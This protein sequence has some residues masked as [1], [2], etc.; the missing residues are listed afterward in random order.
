MDKRIK[1]SCPGKTYA[2][3]TREVLQ[4]RNEDWWGSATAVCDVCRTRVP[5]RNMVKLPIHYLD[6]TIHDVQVIRD[7]S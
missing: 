2:G 3:S 4:E 1:I 7:N 5:L 6:V